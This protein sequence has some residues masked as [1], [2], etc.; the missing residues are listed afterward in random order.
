MTRLETIKLVIAA[1][2]KDLLELTD[3]ECKVVVLGIEDMVA[4]DTIPPTEIVTIVAKAL[5]MSMENLRRKTRKSDPVAARQIIF[6]LLRKYHKKMSLKEMTRVLGMNLYH[7]TVIHSLHTAE[8]RLDTDEDFI[9][10][11]NTAAAAVAQWQQ[12]L[13]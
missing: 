8:D 6:T 5:N 7:T 11:Y 1:A 9:I 10:Q 13:K 2:E 12:V 3:R 4:E